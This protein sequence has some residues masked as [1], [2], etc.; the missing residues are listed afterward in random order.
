MFIIKIAVENLIYFYISC[1]HN[2]YQVKQIYFFPWEKIMY[3][4]VCWHLFYKSCQLKKRKK[5]KNSQKKFNCS[6]GGLRCVKILFQW[7]WKVKAKFFIFFFF[8]LMELSQMYDITRDYCIIQC[9][10]MY[11]Y[12]S[13]N[14]YKYICI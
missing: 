4:V 1:K 10:R 12:R 7:C 8:S 14:I 3:Q 5:I 9:H 2:F 11:A 13:R 6:S